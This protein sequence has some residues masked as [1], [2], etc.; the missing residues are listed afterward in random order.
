MAFD[1]ESLNLPSLYFPTQNVTSSNS[2]LVTAAT[3][4]GPGAPIGSNTL[5]VT[6]LASAAQSTFNWTAPS[7]ADTMTIQV[8]D[9][10]A[11]TLNVAAGATASQVAS[12]I[13]GNSSLGVYATVQ[14]GPGGNTELVI[15][16]ASTG[17]GNLVNAVDSEGSLGATGTSNVDLNPETVNSDGTVTPTTATTWA[18]PVS[19][20]DGKDAVYYLN[21]STTASYSASDTVTNA[22]PG[23][24]LS[25]LGVTGGNSTDNPITITNQAPGPNTTAIVQAVQQFVTDYNAAINSINADVNTAPASESNPSSNNPNSGSLFGDPELEQLLGDMRV[26]MDTTQTGA[27][28]SATMASLGQIGI[29]SANLSGT[30]TTSQVEG[31]LS[32]NTTQLEAAIQSNPSGVQALLSSWSTSFQR[33]V[34]NVGGVTGALYSRTQGNDAMVTSLNSQVTSEKALFTEEEQTMEK[35]WA[36]VESTL[37][38]LDN[39]KTNFSAFSDG[40][41]SSSSSSSS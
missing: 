37:E 28:I 9:N 32:V 14:T 31:E 36:Q 17:A 4:D 2:S 8:G 3:S 13:N 5:T 19:Q 23:V 27:G 24:T 1:A 29:T 35:Q 26:S 21:G 25:L 16:S 11:V 40:L 38:S 41:T 33:T 39:Q 6:S 20:T 34:N 22:I 30:A 18:A 7:A 10:S 12:Q 15:S